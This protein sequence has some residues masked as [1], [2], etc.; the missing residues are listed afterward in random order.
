MNYKNNSPDTLKYIWIHLWPNAYK[1]DRTALSEQL[2]NIGRRNF[3]YAK[4]QERGYINQ[5]AFLVND[6]VAETIDHPRH[7]DI[8]QLLLPTPLP[9]GD[10]ATIKTPFH[11]K[12]PAIFS[13]SGHNGNNYQITQWYPK[14]AVYDRKGWHPMPYLDLGEFYSEFGTYDVEITLP[15]KYILAATGN[16]VSEK[17]V[18][19]FKIYSFHQENVHDFAW[20]TS[21]DFVK[22]SMTASIDGKPLTLSVF[23]KKG[24][25][26]SWENTLDV[27]KEAVEL[28]NKWIGPYPYDVVTVVESQDED[29]GM[30]YPTI[31]V[32]SN[33]GKNTMARD[34]VIH[35]E[36]GHNWFY[37]I[38][39]TNERKHPWMDEG[40]N[41]FY[42]RR[43]D[44]VVLKQRNVTGKRFIRQFSESS[45][46]SGML[47]SLYNMKADQPIETPSPD[48]AP[49]NYALIAYTK[50]SQWMQLLEKTLGRENFDS[51]MKRYYSEWKFKHPYP[52][53]FKTL[54]ESVHRDSLDHIFDLLHKK[55]QLTSPVKKKTVVRPLLSISED[56]SISSIS[57][58]PALG[59]NMYDKIQIG[60]LIHNYNLPLQSVRFL[61]APL[62]AT[63]SKTFNGLG[64]IEYNHFTGKGGKWKLFLAASKFNMNS[65]IDERGKTNFLSF[66]KTTP[67]VEYEFAR[68]SPLSPLRKYI[69][70]K[71]FSIRETM[72]RF[73][74]DTLTNSFTAFYPKQS[75][76]LN[77]LQFGIENN[78]TLYPY[79]ITL[80]AEQGDGFLKTR[81]TGNYHYNYA[82]GGGLQ[83]RAFAGKFFYTGEKTLAN[84]F[85]LDRYHFNMTGSNGYE[86]YTYSDYFIGRNEF[87]GFA[88]Q[89]IMNQ[90]G[91]FKVRTDLLSSKVGR[92]DNWLAAINFSSSI[93]KEINPLSVLP[94]QL[95]LKVF[96]DV[97]TYAEAWDKENTS[98]KFLYDAGI[99]LSFFNVVNIYYPILYSKVYDEYY[100]SVVSENKFKSRISFTIELQNISLRKYFPQVPF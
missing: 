83:V 93:P 29:G 91:A 27:M 34:Q 73:E 50:A 23:Y 58:A 84:R 56:N 24:R 75:R 41:S 45:S 20:F 74:R 100:K 66:I 92:S 96:A 72:L 62:Y 77:Q 85:S 12:L 95:P 40:M 49:M 36:I 31:T 86:D 32:I 3:Y 14:P 53:D 71:H 22:E 65:F 61:I 44:S 81:L 21:K 19:S 9:P 25:K 79:S 39:A 7:Q 47:N 6:Q 88:S 11:V 15:E 28:R 17:V 60:A 87:D 37:G 48:F 89:Q 33:F 97:G 35:H 46:Y 55:G 10:S 8:I 99:Q 54:A 98:G 1:N 64:R 30:E 43:T 26:N 68:S 82:G 80:Q 76:Y 42:D 57:I 90:D 18:D 4:E 2:L 69:R 5:L 59:Y 63:G 16:L 13:R 52:E 94:I 70:L 51:L 67:G 78:R 38:I